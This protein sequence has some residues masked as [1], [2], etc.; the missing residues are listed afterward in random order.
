[1]KSVYEFLRDDSLE[2]SEYKLETSLDEI[3][4]LKTGADMK[5][6]DSQKQ[7]LA[8]FLDWKIDFLTDLIKSIS[9]VADAA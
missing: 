3:I 6:Y 7:T 1:M 5:K 8:T 4:L 9:H 2:C